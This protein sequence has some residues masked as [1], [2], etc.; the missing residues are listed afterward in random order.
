MSQTVLLTHAVLAAGAPYADQVSEGSYLQDIFYTIATAG[1]LL[2]VGGIGLIDAGLVRRKN[3]L[4]TWIQ[5]LISALIGAGSMTIVGF[6]IWEWQYYQALGVPGSLQAALSDWSLFGASFL[7]NSQDLDPTN[8]PEQDVYQIF[9]AFFMAYTAVAGALLHSAGL[10][11][12]KASAIYIISAVAGGLVIPV[13]LYLTWGSV[14]PLTKLGVHD[15]IGV[16]SLYVV[17]GVWALIIAWRAKPR[18]GAFA[19]DA[20]TIGPVPHNASVSALG[21]VLIMFGGIFAFLGC[22]YIVPGQ[23]YFGISGTQSGFGLVVINIFMAY[24]GGGLGGAV[25]AYL[26]KSPAMALL[27]VVAGC[28]GA[29]TS[30]DTGLPW[31]IFIV[32]FLAPF[33]VWGVSRLIHR[34]GVDEKKVVPLALGGGIYGALAGGIVGWGHSTG[35]FFGL[36][37]EWALGV[38]SINIGWQI[39]GLLVVIVIA[40]VTGLVVVLGIEFTIGLRVTEKQELAGL[41]ATYWNSST[42]PYDDATPEPMHWSPSESTS[43]LSTPAT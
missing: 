41:D 14:S 6:G 11:R 27:G 18:L 26:T 31:Q 30:L 8:Y 3:L 42:S 16:Y 10:E 28:V 40:A 38:A 24:V 17:V 4:D 32:A 22:G 35:G 29:G 13:C 1:L 15:Y 20:R 19:L 39:L 12:V 25:I 21:V 37:G 34:I 5:K 7:H 23:G 36:K 2:I 33:A 9:V 43:R